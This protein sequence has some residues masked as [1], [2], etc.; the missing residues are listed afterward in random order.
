MLKFDPKLTKCPL[1]RAENINFH[2]KDFRDVDI[3]KCATCLVQFMNPQYSND[4]LDK[5][6]ANYIN[7]SD[8]YTRMKFSRQQYSDYFSII[9]KHVRIDS[10][11]LLDIGCGDGLLLNTASKYKWNAEGYDV[12]RETVE[13][14]KKR[15]GLPVYSGDFFNIEWRS[16]YYNLVT[17]HQV[18]EHLKNPRKYLEQVHE[19]LSEGGLLFIA[20]PNINSLSARIKFWLE[21][22]GLR[23]KNIGSYYDTDH[24][25]VYFCPKVLS[26]LLK[27]L[28]YDVLFTRNGF[29][30]ESSNKSPIM[31]FITHN[32]IER[33][34]W[35]SVFILVARKK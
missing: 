17:M 11:S 1:C 2:F 35:R 3:F 14:V 15:I 5:F 23:K 13:R 19:L 8:I 28:G 20:S 9:E 12:D 32:I 6:Y 29:K 33:L 21:S 22:K 27:Q 30:L 10:R 16:N 25:L 31:K 34:W 4:Y 24:H 18:L 7:D 26:S